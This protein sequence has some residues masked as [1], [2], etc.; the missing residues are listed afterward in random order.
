MKMK[1]IWVFALLLCLIGCSTSET[2]ALL[3]EEEETLYPIQFNL[4]LNTE[5]LPFSTTKSMPSLSIPEPTTKAEGDDTD[6]SIDEG[7][8]EGEEAGGKEEDTP[9]SDEPVTDGQLYRQIEYIVYKEDAEKRKVYVKHQSFTEDNSNGDFGIIYDKFQAGT[10]HIAFITH[11]SA[12]PVLSEGI[13]TFD[14]I[15]DTF[16]NVSTFEI[17]SIS[18]SAETPTLARIIGKV[19]F[20]STDEVPDEQAKFSIQ[21]QPY[22]LGLDIF[23][24]KAI[25]SEQSHTIEKTITPDDKGK[26]GSHQFFTFVPKEE[27]GI[28][29]TLTSS[30]AEGGTIRQR[31]ITGLKP[32]ANQTIRYTG[33]LYTAPKDNDSF[34]LTIEN[35]GNWGATEENTLPDFVEE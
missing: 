4:Q 22:L 18:S 12:T 19:E 23:T 5:I 9:G 16:W 14:E 8:G 3:T 11:S 13:L 2:D 34:E 31:E 17:S 27:T 7:E 29:L 30:N 15:S 33:L 35:D 10:Y 25:S 24:G 28:Q 20:V 1:F 6:T 26:K 32:L 21:I